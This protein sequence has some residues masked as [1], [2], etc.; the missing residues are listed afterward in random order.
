LSTFHFLFLLKVPLVAMS[1]QP[2]QKNTVGQSLDAKRVGTGTAK[3]RGMMCPLAAP[4]ETGN[5]S[6]PIPQN[7]TGERAVTECDQ[8]AKV[9][10]KTNLPRGK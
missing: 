6:A 3:D 9:F 2:G 8:S 10:G 1:E 4:A 7:D 5:A